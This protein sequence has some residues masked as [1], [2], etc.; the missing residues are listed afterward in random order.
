MSDSSRRLCRQSNECESNM[1]CF[2]G[3]CRCR[4]DSSETS[5]GRCI[6]R[7]RSV[8]PDSQCGQMR[9]APYI[10]SRGQTHNHVAKGHPNRPL[11]IRVKAE[12]LQRCPRDGSCRLPKCFC[13]QSGMEIPNQLSASEVPQMVLLTFNDP[14]TDQSIKI[15]KS[16]FDGRF[17][18]PNGCPVKATFFVSHEWNNYDQTQWLRS[19]GH[20]IA[21]NSFSAEN[22]TVASPSRWHQELN[23]MKE[24]LRQFSYIR[25]DDIIGFRAPYLSLGGENQ[26][27]AM[28][29]NGFRFESTM[30]TNGQPYW[31]QTLGYSVAWNCSGMGCPR[32]PYPSI[33]EIPIG[34][35]EV[36][37]GDQ[38]PRSI[39]DIIQSKDT[40]ESVATRLFNNFLRYYNYNRAPFVLEMD[41][42]FLEAL[43]EGG[44]VIAVE[45]FLEKVLNVSDVY[46][47]SASQL[48]AWMETPAR[49][50]KIHNFNAWKCSNPYENYFRPCEN[51]STCAFTC[52]RGESHAFRVCG[53]CPRA[54]PVLGDPLGSGHH[55]RI[56]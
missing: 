53:S 44:A 1:E 27:A 54:Y 14:I 50:T 17:R 32:K 19:R 45:K 39:V 4:P 28:V 12:T 29:R 37:A 35:I 24:A 9:D 56:H 41:K 15:F 52:E 22:L 5:D 2:N 21:V 55:T 43:P 6:I 34:S 7:V 18:N 48:I 51:P 3:E 46:V 11:V 13:S 33:W 42:R 8:P 47:V 31:P 38:K 36:V 16:V 30:R 23:G 20:E 10:P 49:L 40:S 26:F 25:K